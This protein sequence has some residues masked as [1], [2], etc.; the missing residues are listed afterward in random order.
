M[1]NGIG[2]RRSDADR[3][4][5][6]DARAP[7]RPV[8]SSSTKETSRIEPGATERCVEFRRDDKSSWWMHN[9]GLSKQLPNRARI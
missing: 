2:N 9:H 3:S 5:F 1:K 8:F 7:I 6:P 4:Q